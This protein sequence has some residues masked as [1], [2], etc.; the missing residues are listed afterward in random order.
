MQFMSRMANS[1]TVLRGRTFPFLLH[2][3][4][5]GMRHQT[6]HIVERHSAD[7]PKSSVDFLH[8]PAFSGRASS[9]EN[10]QL[11][12]HMFVR[13]TIRHHSSVFNDEIYNLIRQLIALTSIRTIIFQYYDLWGGFR[14][15]PSPRLAL[16]SLEN[17]FGDLTAWVWSPHDRQFSCQ[18]C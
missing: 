7:R 12:T 17:D 5:F 4:S 11:H 13:N 16:R 3:V 2:A 18:K 10:V 9:I 8:N 6:L 15:I 1:R 14:P